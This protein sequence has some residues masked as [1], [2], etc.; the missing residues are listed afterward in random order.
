MLGLAADR[1]KVWKLTLMMHVIMILAVGLFVASLP[2][3]DHVYSADSP[4]PISLA[5]G[6]VL[7]NITSNSMYTINATLLAK[8]V[9]SATVSRGVL[10]YIGA[11]FSSCGIL[12]IDGVGGHIYDL[13]KRNPFYIVISSEG[14]TIVLCIVL[15]IAKQLS[16]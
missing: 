3:E 11:F 4:A 9:S 10:L 6:F 14:L 13:D 5:L 7:C 16:V 15:A 12:L 8:S 1:V 2:S